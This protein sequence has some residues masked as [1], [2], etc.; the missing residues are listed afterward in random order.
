MVSEQFM[1]INFLRKMV[2]IIL[3]YL[4]Y[5]LKICLKH[6]YSKCFFLLL[7]HVVYNIYQCPQE[8]NCSNLEEKL[9]NI[10]GVLDR[11]LKPDLVL[12]LNHLD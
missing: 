3:Q 1:K 8:Y 2:R 12:E 7:N 11:H 5:L 4:T 9:R 6:K 10:E